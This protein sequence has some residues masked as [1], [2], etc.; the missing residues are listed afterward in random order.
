MPPPTVRPLTAADLP[1]YVALRR[2]MLADAPWAF[3]ADESN[4]RGLD[5]EGL[6]RS[7]AGPGFALIGAVDDHAAVVG[8]AGLIRNQHAKM[9]HRA[10]IWGVYVTPPSRG[11][12]LAERI[13]TATID[14]ASTWPGVNSV[15]LSVSEKATA[16]RKLYERLGFVAWGLEPD[17]L[18]LGS[19]SYAEAHMIRTL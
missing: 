11:R 3:A 1:S 5:P 6:A 17:A 10:L 9:A 7:L 2:E 4:D 14:L 13:M 16:A 18:H 12:G 15:G 8:A 19:E